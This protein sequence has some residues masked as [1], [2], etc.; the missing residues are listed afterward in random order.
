M[1][2][3]IASDGTFIA[4][5]T[6]STPSDAG[7]A[8]TSLLKG[9]ADIVTQKNTATE[10]LNAVTQTETAR[11]A[12]SA[13]DLYARA[14]DSLKAL[15]G[16]Q[17]SEKSSVGLATSNNLMD[18][19]TLLGN[20]ILDPK[21]FTS[22]GRSQQRAALQQ[23]LSI[24][25]NIHGVN[26]LDAQAN[27]TAAQAGVDASTARQNMAV[28]GLKAQIA[29][30]Q[31]AKDQI[32]SNQQLKDAAITTIQK[33]DLEKSLASADSKTGLISIGGLQYRPDEVRSRIN[34]LSAR[35][36]M[37]LL[38][39][40][41]TN[42]T[43]MQAKAVHEEYMLNTM[44]VDE[45]N[46]IRM[47][48]NTDSSGY[49]Y[50]PQVIDRVYNQKQQVYADNAA[51]LQ[52]E[53]TASFFDQN[54]FVNEGKYTQ[55]LQNTLP[56]D[57][58]LRANLA[59]Y[60]AQL[61]WAMK[62]AQSATDVQSK[63]TAID[64]AVKAK[65]DFNTAA[66]KEANRQAGSDK[67]MAD[68]IYQKLTTGQM[69][70]DQLQSVITGRISNFKSVSNLIPDRDAARLN[71]LFN[72]KYDALKQQNTQ[73]SVANA[74]LMNV[75]ENDKQI[76]QDAAQKAYVEF[77]QTMADEA[78]N[79]ALD[80]QPILDGNPL[81]GV[82]SLGEW[83]GLLNGAEQ[84][85]WR[86][87]QR[88]Y[89]LSDQQLKDVQAKKQVE[90]KNLQEIYSA[91]AEATDNHLF[92]GLEGL[93]PGLATDY[94]NWLVDNADKLSTTFMGTIPEVYRAMLGPDL[95]SRADAIGNNMIAARNRNTMVASQKV[96]EYLTGLN[97]PKFMNALLLQSD[98]TLEPSQ[99][100]A[101][102]NNIIKPVLDQ[103]GKAGWSP[104]ETIKNIDTVLT[105]TRPDDKILASAL[106]KHLSQRPS[107]ESNIRQLVHEFVFRN[108]SPGSRI[109]NTLLPI[110]G[111]DEQMRKSFDVNQTNLG[112]AYK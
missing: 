85:A 78:M 91:K 74:G 27:I 22:A 99:R 1:T 94:G 39:P 26:S 69:Q 40:S 111:A 72:E 43:Y 63:A 68:L 84:D 60:Q 64:S 65:V 2:N 71:K 16:I 110:Y 52:A 62:A 49:V 17:Q 103:G 95:Q 75:K 112:W 4:P 38:A 92:L 57:S 46:K 24:A 104:Q 14:Q 36:Q 108:A 87:V 47:N 66:Q 10:N 70:P 33:P 29:A 11:V 18:R 98:Q 83:R 25:E 34:D 80:A 13:D 15:D 54:Y 23:D 8:V 42:P 20:Q 73:F 30:T 28:E 12:K 86:Q 48:N 50:T 107:I 6:P 106:K 56:G 105:Q 79:T 53:S 96:G 19:F 9:L 61:A 31:L 81:K 5:I 100:E 97:D 21:N 101:I 89:G 44:N 59:K 67:D 37:S 90:G 32:V 7:L 35:E 82:V 109:T 77:Q 58:P 45:L 55:D 88:Q 102:F 93:K 41:E 3:A 76:R 51:Q